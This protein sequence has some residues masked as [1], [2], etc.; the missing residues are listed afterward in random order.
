MTAKV[1]GLDRHV[2]RSFDYPELAA[3]IAP[4]CDSSLARGSQG[5]LQVGELPAVCRAVT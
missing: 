1:R 4:G 5:V 2:D 3:R